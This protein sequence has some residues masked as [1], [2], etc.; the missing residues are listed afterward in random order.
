MNI[1]LVVFVV[2]MMFWLFFG[3]YVVWD[4]PRPGP[5]LGLALIPFLCVALIGYEVYKGSRV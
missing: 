3:L 2:L 1:R 4:A 5:G